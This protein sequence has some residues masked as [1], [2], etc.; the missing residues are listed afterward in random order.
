MLHLNPLFHGHHDPLRE[1]PS[2]FELRDAANRGCVPNLHM[3]RDLGLDQPE[4]GD[5]G[6]Q[7]RWRIGF[8]W[9]IYLQ[10]VAH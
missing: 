2:R 3:R 1:P 9:P 10:A 5:A 8:R 6:A 7:H 4:G